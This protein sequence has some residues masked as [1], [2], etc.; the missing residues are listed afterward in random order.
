MTELEHQ[1][2]IPTVLIETD[3]FKAE[4]IEMYEMPYEKVID[5]LA[6]QGPRQMFKMLD[7]FKNAI[8]DPD[9]AKNLEVLSFNDMAEIAGQWAAKSP[10]RWLEFGT[11]EVRD[12]RPAHRKID[13]PLNK[14]SSDE[15]DLDWDDED[16]PF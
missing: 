7:L 8:L 4:V 11:E 5:M 6:V 14:T 15:D 2:D 16:E 13:P 3:H 12:K 9:K 10:V 1:W